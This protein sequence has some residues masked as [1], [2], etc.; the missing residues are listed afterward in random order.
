MRDYDFAGQV[1]LIMGGGRGLG[2]AL[3]QAMAR[4]GAAVAFVVRSETQLRDAA[5]ADDLYTLRLRTS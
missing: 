1:A 3:A 5:Q 4:A 2:Q